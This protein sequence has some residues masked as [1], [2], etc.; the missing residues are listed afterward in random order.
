[1]LAEAKENYDKDEYE[2]LSPSFGDTLNIRF[3]IH[4][5]GDIH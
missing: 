3:L 2:G 1:M 4:F 5:V